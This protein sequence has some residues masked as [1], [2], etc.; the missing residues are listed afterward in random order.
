MLTLFNDAC[1]LVTT[2]SNRQYLDDHGAQFL[3][4]WADAARVLCDKV[5]TYPRDVETVRSTLAAAGALC[6]TVA[7]FLVRPERS[8]FTHRDVAFLANHFL[9]PFTNR[10]AS[11]ALLHRRSSV[12][13]GTETG[14]DPVGFLNEW[15]LTA[16]L[17][18]AAFEILS[19]LLKH[20]ASATY[21]HM[22]AWLHHVRAL[23]LHV[24]HSVTLVER[25][26]LN[27][28][29][30]ATYT[31]LVSAA[32]GCSRLWEEMARPLHRPAL[33]KYLPFCVSDYVVAAQAFGLTAVPDVRR[34][35]RQGAFALLAALTDDDCQYLFTCLD[36]GAKATF[37]AFYAAYVKLYKFTGQT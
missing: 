27:D 21:K 19:A 28:A 35:L 12:S 15:W 20:R 22:H 36:H 6:H 29:D 5:P 4:V 9:L 34:T 26:V 7:G 8:V 10:I 33:G 25:S 30:G 1:G 32:D 24:M 13:D 3:S 18:A 17:A 23:Q 31:A 14:N 16:G 2:G 11:F 37:K